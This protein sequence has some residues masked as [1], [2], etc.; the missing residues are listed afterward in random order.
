MHLMLT[1]SSFQKLTEAL[2]RRLFPQR[3]KFSPSGHFSLLSVFCSLSAVHTEFSP[4]IHSLQSWSAP[5]P[6]VHVLTTYPWYKSTNHHRLTVSPMCYQA[7]SVSSRLRRSFILLPLPW[8]DRQYGHWQHSGPL[9]LGC[10]CSKTTGNQH[11]FFINHPFLSLCNNNTKWSKTALGSLR[12]LARPS[13]S[14]QSQNLLLKHYRKCCQD[15]NRLVRFSVLALILDGVNESQPFPEW[16]KSK[17]YF[18]GH[19]KMARSLN[20]CT[21]L[22]HFSV[23]ASPAV[24]HS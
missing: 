6:H 5:I 22:S 15:P 21:S 8:D 14:C 12:S 4:F 16:L 2:S 23:P 3:Q 24:T 19:K 1:A 7:S 17:V 20:L 18:L 13:T 11:L 9:V 10:L